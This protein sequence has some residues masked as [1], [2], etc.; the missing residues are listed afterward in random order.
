MADLMN[1]VRVALHSE[2]RPRSSPLRKMRGLGYP[3]LC[4]RPYQEEGYW[5]AQDGEGV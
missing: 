1:M 2:V 4:I 3:R 5:E